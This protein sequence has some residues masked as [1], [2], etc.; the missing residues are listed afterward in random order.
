MWYIKLRPNKHIR[1]YTQKYFGYTYR[2][3]IS[4][5]RKFQHEVRE[6]HTD[7]PI[8]KCIVKT[9]DGFA[10]RYLK[11]DGKYTYKHIKKA[12]PVEIFNKYYIQYI[13]ASRIYFN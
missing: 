2:A 4:D 3:H 12:I 7:E 6:K 13:Y 10:W 8:Y 11:D 5:L 1:Q 9:R